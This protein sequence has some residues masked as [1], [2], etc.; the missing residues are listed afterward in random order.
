M[1]RFNILQYPLTSEASMKKI[2]EHNT[3]VF[4]CNPKANKHQIKAAFLKYMDAISVVKV[5]TLNTPQG[6]KKAF[7]KLGTDS[8]A[9]DIANKIGII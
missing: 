9:L 2:E 6:K 5:N 8:E 1:D 3:L 4:I 7:I